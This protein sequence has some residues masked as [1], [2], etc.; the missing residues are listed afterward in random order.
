MTTLRRGVNRSGGILQGSGDRSSGLTWIATEAGVGE[1]LRARRTGSNGT[2]TATGAAKAVPARRTG[3]NGIGPANENGNANPSASGGESVP[4]RRSGPNGIGLAN[5]NGNVNPSAS[6]RESTLARHAVG[7][8]DHHRA[9]HAS[10][11]VMPQREHG[12]PAS[13]RAAE[14][15]NLASGSNA[16]GPVMR[17]QDQYRQPDRVNR[18]FDRG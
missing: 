18:P 14:P 13:R 11:D 8:P 12:E 9:S 2:A 3:P 4:A 6:G 17:R 7:G 1:A 10:T 15:A 16:H 5:E